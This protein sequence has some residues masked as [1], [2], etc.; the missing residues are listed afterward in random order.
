MEFYKTMV[1]NEIK[2]ANISK[3]DNVLHLGCGPIPATCIIIAKKNG[4]K[5]TGVD[6][7]SNMVKEALYCISKFKDLNNV[8]IKHGEV[9]NFPIETFD[10]IVISQGVEPRSQILKH[11]A[12]SMKARARVVLRITSSSTVEL[13]D[14]DIFLKDL[15]LINKKVSQDQYGLLVSMLLLKKQKNISQEGRNSI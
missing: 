10:I 11:I 9:S 13:I 15:F 4:A 1:E 12:Q 2:I 8:N 3:G 7:N 6:N 5:I 14:N